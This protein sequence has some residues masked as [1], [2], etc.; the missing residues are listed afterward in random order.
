MMPQRAAVTLPSL[1][2]GEELIAVPHLAGLD[3]IL[4]GPRAND[5]SLVRVV[6][7]GEDVAAT[8]GM[9]SEN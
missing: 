3:A 5:V 8:S 9:C 7:N 6:F 4:A 1:W 2:R